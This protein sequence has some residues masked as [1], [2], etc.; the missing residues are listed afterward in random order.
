LVVA[1]TKDS[2]IDSSDAF[3]C[4]AKEA[5]AP[6]TYMRILDMDHYVRKKEDVIKESFDWL[7]KQL[8]N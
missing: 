4:K 3:V 8:E 2:I 6:V 1:G 5:G 7:K